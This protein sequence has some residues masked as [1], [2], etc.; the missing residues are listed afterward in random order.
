MKNTRDDVNI[1]ISN[2]GNPPK[3]TVSGKDMAVV[4][5]SYN[6][7]T[8]NDVSGGRNVLLVEGY[9]DGDNFTTTIKADKM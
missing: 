6:Y 8:K 1:E 7:E 9:I 2:D 3:V 4:K 5:V